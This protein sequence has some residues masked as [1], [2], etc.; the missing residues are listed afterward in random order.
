MPTIITKT[1]K[2]SGGDYTSL[3]SFEANEQAD[4][5]ITDEIKRAECYN[6]EDTTPVSFSGWVTDSQRFIV[7]F[8][9]DFHRGKW[10]TDVYRLKASALNEGAL[11]L[12]EN[13]MIIDGL[14][15]DDDASGV[16]THNGI[17]LNTQNINNDIRIFNTITRFTGNGTGTGRGIRA[18]STN[19]KL[20]IWNSLVYDF[21]NRGINTLGNV[22]IWNSV[23]YNNGDFGIVRSGG[24]INIKNCA[25]FN[26]TDDISVTVG[27]KDHIAS[28][29]GDGTNSVQP[30]NWND[31]FIDIAN[32]DF[33]LKNS[34]TDLI[35]AGIDDPSSG[36]FNRDIDGDKFVSPWNIGV[37]ETK[38][39]IISDY[40][41][42]NYNRIDYRKINY[43][44]L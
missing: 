43:N 16:G 6:F 29:D 28:D 11:I 9:N 36:L 40:E 22:D 10:N 18:S 32:R 5:T 44:K 23:I 4:L 41:L 38:T 39:K 8:A 42:I 1:I 25:V 13:Y 37:D 15:I 31:V 7:C 34:D 24:T 17:F 2:A 3:A 20:K 30:T 14:Q 26:H 21:Q 12:K 19:T 27:N 33:H 35:S